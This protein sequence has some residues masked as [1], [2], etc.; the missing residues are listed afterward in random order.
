VAG[1]KSAGAAAD[2]FAL[3]TLL[4][5]SPA[6]T[7]RSVQ[8]FLMD[9]LVTEI[10]RLRSLKA[11]LSVRDAAQAAYSRA[12]VAQDKLHFQAKQFRDKGRNDKVRRRRRGVAGRAEAGSAGECGRPLSLGDAYLPATATPPLGSLLRRR[13]SWSPKSPRRWAS[14]SA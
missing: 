14:A 6:T 3:T 2:G 13:T 8:I 11:L 12:W 10:H 4:R 5:L 1:R 7:V 9:G